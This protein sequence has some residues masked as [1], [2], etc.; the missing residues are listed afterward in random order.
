MQFKSQWFGEALATP[1]YPLDSREE[2]IF[3]AL[4]GPLS[5]SFGADADI[6]AAD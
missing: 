4:G 3:E 1:A 5:C 6:A 2:T